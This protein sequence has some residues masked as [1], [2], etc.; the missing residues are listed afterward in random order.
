[1]NKMMIHNYKIYITD[2]AIEKI[3]NVIKRCKTRF[4]FEISKHKILITNIIRI[5]RLAKKNYH[6]QHPRMF[7]QNAT[8][9]CRFYFPANI[10]K[11]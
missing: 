3:K 10:P 4:G 2:D 11:S 9:H 6:F 1:M 8:N 7:I 5:Q